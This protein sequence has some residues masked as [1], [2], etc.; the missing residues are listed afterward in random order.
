MVESI[1]PNRYEVLKEKIQHDRA[2]FK[3]REHK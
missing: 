1:K 2:I 3:E